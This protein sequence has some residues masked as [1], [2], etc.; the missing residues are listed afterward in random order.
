MIKVIRNITIAASAIVGLVGCNSSD[1]QIASKN[2]SYKSDNFEVPRRVIFY[3]GITDKYLLTIEGRCSINSNSRKLAVT[4]KIGPNS[5]KKH[6]LGLSDNVT[7][8]VEQLN[9]IDVSVYH[10]SVVFKPQAI[11]PD[12]DFKGSTSALSKVV[13]PDNKD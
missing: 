7:Y 1:A 3:N 2:I 4:C 6:Y 13:I 12:I 9:P 10:Y 8:F 5:Y 11:I